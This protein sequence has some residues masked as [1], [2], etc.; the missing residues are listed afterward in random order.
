[1]LANERWPLWQVVRWLNNWFDGKNE[2]EE[3]THWSNA[4]QESLIY[5][6][7]W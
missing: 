4:D 2:D 3:R 1:M 7:E 6:A 5:F